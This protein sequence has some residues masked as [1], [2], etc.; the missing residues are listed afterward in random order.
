VFQSEI[1]LGSQEASNVDLDGTWE[2][3]LLKLVANRSLWS[4]SHRS[5]TYWA[6][7]VVNNGATMNNYNPQMMRCFVCHPIRLE[8]I[9][10][11]GK[12]KGLVSYN[13]NHDTSVLKQH[14]CHEHLNLY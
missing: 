2:T 3:L 4:P 12:H 10:V 1:K 5:S 6:S 13:K 8:L 7:F 9:D 14:V 11:Q